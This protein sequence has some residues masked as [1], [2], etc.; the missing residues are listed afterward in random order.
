M[1]I[2]GKLAFWKHDTSPTGDIGK[3]LDL[4]LGT[5]RMG[6]NQDRT[7]VNMDRAGLPSEPTGLGN[8]GESPDVTG[9]PPSRGG[10]PK[11]YPGGLEAVDEH[12]APSAFDDLRKTTQGGDLQTLSKNIEIISSKMDALKAIIDNLAI[13]INKIE[14]IADAEHEEDQKR[15]V[16][17]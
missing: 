10:P 4:G 16:R 14:K 1:G 8:I 9:M 6:V 15:E 5:D 3:P 2:L 12:E 11:M 7:G 17:W 13:K